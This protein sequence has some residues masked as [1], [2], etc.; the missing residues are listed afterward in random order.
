MKPT[1]PAEFEMP[2][3]QHFDAS[4]LKVDAGVHMRKYNS[5]ISYPEKSYTSKEV[6]NA[7]PLRSICG[8]VLISLSRPLS[9]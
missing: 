3:L 5:L 6:K 7:L 8:W 1:H 4:E 2:E 9:P